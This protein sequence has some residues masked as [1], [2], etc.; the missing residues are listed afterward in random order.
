M[1][2]PIRLVADSAPQVDVPVPGA[3]TLAPISL[4]VPLVVDVRDDHGIAS[5]IVESRRVSRL[6]VTDS[7]RRE[8]VAV[9]GGTP[10]RA[11]LTHTL[12]LTRRGLL[13]GD[14]LRYFA[15]ATDNTPQHQAGRSR[16]YVLRLPTMS[17]VRAAQRQASDAV[18]G[19][20][21]SVSAASK[22][23]ERQ[24][25]DLARERPR[26]SDGR[27]EK[28]GESLS[29]E[30][31]KKAEGVAQSQQELMRQAEALKQSL[32]SLQKSAE[33]AGLGDSA[34][35]RELSEIREQLERAL[36][37]ELRER[38]QELRQAL[39]DLDAERTQEALERL[40]EA[41]RET[42][43]GARAEPRAVQARR[44]RGRSREPEQGV[45]GARAGAA[46][47]EP[48]GERRGQLALGPGGARAGGAGRF[49][50]RRARQARQGR[51]RFGRGRNGSM[52]RGTRPSRRD[53]R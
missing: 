49:A 21:D 28:S 38:L 34:W 18:A 35:Q 8:T 7:A 51:G 52:P 37:P 32:E 43:R 53:S 47:M 1:R 31:A 46:G 45:Q 30:E 44:A 10:D 50:G 4:Q 20:L 33:A 17:E 5:V 27:G 22:Q 24:T 36:S 39:K 40:A 14:T 25:D 9:P 13:P 12:D 2:L 41:Q 6:G 11:I 3:D 15:V 16:E 48:A 26:A 23:L 29:F 19:A 42:A